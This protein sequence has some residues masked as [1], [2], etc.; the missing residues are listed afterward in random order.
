MEQEDGRGRGRR[1]F[2]LMCVGARS[3]PGPLPC[4]LVWLSCFLAEPPNGSGPVWLG[5]ASCRGDG[6]VETEAPFSRSS[7]SSLKSRTINAVPMVLSGGTLVS[8]HM[9]REAAMCCTRAMCCTIWCSRTTA[10]CSRAAG[11]GRSGQALPSAY[12]NWSH[13]ARKVC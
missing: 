9:A 12:A 1:L 10:S 8:Q 11:A 2:M 5:V 7:P 6:G 4:K 13:V 3:G